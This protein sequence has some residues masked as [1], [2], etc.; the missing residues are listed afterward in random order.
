MGNPLKANAV[1]SSC[2][3]ITMTRTALLM[4]HQVRI[5]ACIILM[6]PSAM[7]PWAFSLTII[8]GE[9]RQEWW[10]GLVLYHWPQRA[11]RLSLCIHGQ[12]VATEQI[13]VTVGVSR[14]HGYRVRTYSV[15]FTVVL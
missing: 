13:T 1:A 15:R 9:A 8:C 7:Q 14:L 10:G 12:T 6:N 2:L 11:V 4:T 5:T 3:R